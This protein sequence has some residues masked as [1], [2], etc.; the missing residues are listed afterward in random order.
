MS[1]PRR[2]W[3]IACVSA[4]VATAAAVAIILIARPGASS[5]ARGDAPLDDYGAVPAF[6]FTDQTGGTTTEAWLRG[7]V[8]I[9]DF[10]F[11]RCDTVCPALT[12]RM[13]NLD[14]QTAD[15][16][17]AVRL[18]SFSVDPGHDTAAVLAAYG[19]QWRARP[20]RWRFVTGDA[21]ALRTLIEGPLMSAMVEAG[22]TP[23]GAPDIRH[24][25]HFLLVDGALRIRGV[26]DSNDAARLAAL[27]RDVRRLVS[28]APAP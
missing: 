27:P 15:L 22:T 25:G 5:G 8:T 20:A 7:R 4:A 16:G 17:D 18:L 3:L 21:D 19:A 10:I 1:A 2:P 11:T 24:G 6:G 13:A 9:I 28:Q 23:S 26:Y 12:G 14:E